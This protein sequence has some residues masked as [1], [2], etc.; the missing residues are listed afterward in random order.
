MRWLSKP[1]LGANM[2]ELWVDLELNY[3]CEG[4][5][6]VPAE[7]ELTE[8][9]TL[10]YQ[11]KYYQITDTVLAGFNK[12]KLLDTKELDPEDIQCEEVYYE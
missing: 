12:L 2:K 4:L 9:N 11:G 3:I 8:M 7:F 10:K 5:S 6:I 1:P